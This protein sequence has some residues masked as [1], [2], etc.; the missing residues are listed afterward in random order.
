MHTHVLLSLKPLDLDTKLPSGFHINM[1]KPAKATLKYTY[2]NSRTGTCEKEKS[3][4]VGMETTDCH[5]RRARSPILW[6]G[7]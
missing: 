6:A 5:D 7:S 2:K 1:L 3:R 4:V